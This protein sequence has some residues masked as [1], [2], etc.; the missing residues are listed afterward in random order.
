MP[1][2]IFYSAT[3]ASKQAGGAAARDDEK[4]GGLGDEGAAQPLIRDVS[5]SREHVRLVG[6]A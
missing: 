6:V 2:G 4:D 1:A 5:E 3:D